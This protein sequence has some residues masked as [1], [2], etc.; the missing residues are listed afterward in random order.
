MTLVT[1]VCV[2][3]GGTHHHICNGFGNDFHNLQVVEIISRSKINHVRSFAEHTR[4]RVDMFTQRCLTEEHTQCSLCSTPHSHL[5]PP[6]LTSPHPTPHTFGV[7]SLARPTHALASSR[8]PL[9]MLNLLPNST[10][11]PSPV[12]V[13]PLGVS[14]GIIVLQKKC[15]DLPSQHALLQKA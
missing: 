4:D 13:S 8:S 12:L 15:I 14:R 5:T 10:S 6:H 1:R 2:V 9:R 3:V 7:C 11:F